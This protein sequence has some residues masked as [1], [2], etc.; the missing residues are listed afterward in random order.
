[1][2]AK[3][4]NWKD[5]NS[6]EKL[7]LR[8]DHF[9]STDDIDFISD[10]AKDAYKERVTI[11]R[12]A[13]EMKKVPYRVPV[14][15]MLGE[16]ALRY[17]GLTPY[18][19][20]YNQEEAFDAILKFDMEFQSDVA[21]SRFALSGTLFDILDYRLMKWP[22]R[23]L[24]KESGYQVVER[25][26]MTADEYPHLLSDPSDFLMRKFVPRIFGS[27]KP[28]TM[29][30]VLTHNL[31]GIGPGTFMPFSRPEFKEL[32]EKLIKA[33]EE[34]ARVMK[35][36]QTAAIKTRSAGFPS[37]MGGFGSAPFDALS[38]TLRGTKGI[39]TDLYR[40]PD[41]VIEACE[42]FLPM[43]L[44]MSLEASNRSDSPMIFIPLHKGDDDHM[45]VA[46]FEKFYWPTLK[47]LML[48]IVEEGLIP[49]PFAEGSYN[50][51]L[52]IISEFPKGRSIWYFDKTDMH[53][54]KEILG[55]VCCI[56][57]N[58][59]TSLMLAGTPDDVKSYC[60]DLI[61]FCG[62]DGGYILSSG[63]SIDYST[64]KNLRA[65][66]DFSKEYGVYQ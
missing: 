47:K 53:R 30:P 52:E 26:Y 46:Q 21:S 6:E 40:R 33:G 64:E 65:L 32:T 22:G 62:K 23:G 56:M 54:A 51:R 20:M 1:M 59:P 43:L 11:I 28:L 44:D 38:D 34:S 55:N 63:A 58:V 37:I 66:I 50:H 39:M 19:Q 25:E 3:P 45:S 8:L 14:N 18:D 42:R 60:R 4:D 17:Y 35:I 36:S 2:F 57:G 5:L 12:D 29:F 31:Y 10:E 48:G 61:D 27:M 49:V 24:P 13:V 7:A 16:Y 9:V 41:M 15:P